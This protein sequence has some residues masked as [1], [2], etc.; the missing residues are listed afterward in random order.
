MA[1]WTLNWLS[2]I[3]EPL[4]IRPRQQATHLTFLYFF[5]F[6]LSYSRSFNLKCRR[7]L[8]SE[9]EIDSHVGLTTD[10]LSCY[11]LIQHTEDLSTM[12]VEPA[13]EIGNRGLMKWVLQLDRQGFRTHYPLPGPWCTLDRKERIERIG[14]ISMWCDF[15][16][17]MEAEEGR[18]ESSLQL[19]FLV[20]R[21]EGRL[22]RTVDMSGKTSAF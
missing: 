4:L 16:H 11:C 15:R 10:H 18:K 5:I 6:P 14:V 13:E 8:A 3:I 20:N 21:P 19:C 12:R 22:E 17:K 1:Q 2:L 7:R 9:L